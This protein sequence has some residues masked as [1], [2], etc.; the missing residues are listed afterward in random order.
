MLLVVTQ[1][2]LIVSEGA[3]LSSRAL[4]RAKAAELRLV[5][6]VVLVSKVSLTLRTLPVWSEDLEATCGSNLR[7]L[8]AWAAHRMD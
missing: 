3:L 4:A 7:P 6:I 1:L 8:R 2:L 5:A